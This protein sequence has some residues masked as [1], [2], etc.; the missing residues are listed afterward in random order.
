[1]PSHIPIPLSN[2]LWI[3]TIL[4]NKAA[5]FCQNSLVMAEPFAHLDRNMLLGGIHGGETNGL[6]HQMIAVGTVT[7]LHIKRSGRGPFFAIAIHAEPLDIRAAKEQLFDHRWIA[8]K[9]D[10]HRTAWSE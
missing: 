3:S 10:D 9:V 7:D 8:V 6:H 2:S 1:M 5:M 4:L